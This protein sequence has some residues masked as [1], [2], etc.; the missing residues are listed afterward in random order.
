MQKPRLAL[1]L[2]QFVY[3]RK[4]GASKRPQERRSRA[5]R[6]ILRGVICQLSS[7]DLALSVRAGLITRDEAA[8]GILGLFV[9]ATAFAGFVILGFNIREYYRSVGP[10]R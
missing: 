1:A 7:I 3:E 8:L 9:A 6:D 4:E 2:A 5:W 10:E